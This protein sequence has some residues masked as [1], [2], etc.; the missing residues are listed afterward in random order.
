MNHD[1]TE[2]QRR[3]EAEVQAQRLS[4]YIELIEKKIDAWEA[5]I[6]EIDDLD[7][8]AVEQQFYQDYF[9][10]MLESYFE[11]REEDH[12][13][14]S[15]ITRFLADLDYYQS[16]ARR[17]AG[18]FIT[19]KSPASTRSSVSHYATIARQENGQPRQQ[20]PV[21]NRPPTILPEATRE[22]R[23]Q[24]QTGLDT[25]RAP[26]PAPATMP[27]PSS[28]LPVDQYIRPSGDSRSDQI[29]PLTSQSGSVVP[30]GVVPPGVTTVSRDGHNNI[31]AISGDPVDLERER[32]GERDHH[33]SFVTGTLNTFAPGGTQRI[34]APS[35]QVTHP[36]FG[37]PTNNTGRKE[38]RVSATDGV[39]GVGGRSDEM[40]ERRRQ[41]VE[42]RRRQE[43]RDRDGAIGDN[44]NQGPR[45]FPSEGADWRHREGLNKPS[46]RYTTGGL[47]SLHPVASQLPPPASV[48]MPL[49]HP[50]QSAPSAPTS[51]QLPVMPL[52][53]FDGKEPWT[54]RVFLE[55]F[56]AVVIGSHQ[57]SDLQRLHYLRSCL[58]GEA[59]DAISSVVARE[60]CYTAA[61]KR[62]STIYNGGP[63]EMAALLRRK[64]QGI[65]RGDDGGAKAE[66]KTIREVTTL[67]SEL[68]AHESD[69][70]LLADLVVERLPE[71]AVKKAVKIRLDQPYIPTLELLEKLEAAAIHNLTVEKITAGK[72]KKE[73]VRVVTE[74]SG[75]EEEDTE[76]GE[77]YRMIALPMTNPPPTAFVQREK[78]CP[79]C[80]KHSAGQEERCRVFKS[81]DER[82][83]RCRQ[84]K[85]CFRC[86]R[87]GV[88]HKFRDC[89]ASCLH[90]NGG[91]HASLCKKTHNDRG[92]QK[93]G[94]G[95]QVLVDEGEEGDDSYY[96]E[97][98]E[99]FKGLE[100]D[101]VLP[102]GEIVG[103]ADI[104]PPPFLPRLPSA[105]LLTFTGHVI[106][107]KDGRAYPANIMLDPGAS[108]SLISNSLINR[109]KMDALGRAETAFSGV[110]GATS[111]YQDRRVFQFKVSSDMQGA[112]PIEV[113][114]YELEDPLTGPE[115]AYELT[116][117]DLSYIRKQRLASALLE[118]AT[119]PPDVLV[120]QDP[121]SECLDT[122]V[123][124]VRLPSGM[125]L[126]P[127]TLGFIRTGCMKSKKESAVHCF[128]VPEIV[129]SLQDQNRT[130]E[131]KKETESEDV[132]ILD[133]KRR[134]GEIKKGIHQVLGIPLQIRCQVLMP[135]ELFQELTV[136]TLRTSCTA[137]GEERRV[138][139]VE[140]RKEK[141]VQMLT[142]VRDPNGFIAPLT[143]HLKRLARTF[144]IGERKNG[145]RL[146]EQ[147]V[148][149][150]DNCCSMIRTRNL[151]TPMF[152]FPSFPVDKSNGDG[153]LIIFCTS[154]DSVYAAAVYW[155]SAE[156][157][158][159]HL[160]L[161]QS[162][163]LP[164]SRPDT[165]KFFA[166][167]EAELRA[168]ELG[169]DLLQEAVTA[170][171]SEE[172]PVR[173]RRV[174]CLTDDVVTIQRI[175]E[176]RPEIKEQMNIFALK[177]LENIWE[178][179]DELRREKT[180]KKEFLRWA[181]IQKMKNP[182]RMAA[183]GVNAEHLENP[184]G[185]S[186]Q[187]WWK[188]TEEKGG[189]RTVVR[190]LE[191]PE[192][193]DLV[194]SEGRY[195]HFRA[196]DPMY[197]KIRPDY[198]AA[199]KDWIHPIEETDPLYIPPEE[200]EKIT[201]FN[202]LV[203]RLA[204]K[205]REEHRKENTS[206]MMP[207]DRGI[208]MTIGPLTEAEWCYAESLLMRQHQHRFRS[209][210][211]TIQDLRPTKD[212]NRV[213]R[214]G[215]T[216]QWM[217]EMDTN[218]DLKFPIIIFPKDKLAHLIIKKFHHAEEHGGI[219]TTLQAIRG[220]F[221]IVDGTA[222]VKKEIKRCPTCRKYDHHSHS[223]P[224]HQCL[225]RTIHFRKFEE[226]GVDCMGPIKYCTDKGTEEEMFVLI[227]T[228][229]TSRAI[230]LECST[231][232]N[233]S[234]FINAFDRFL[235]S[236]GGPIRTLWCDTSSYFVYDGRKYRKHPEFIHLT[237]DDTGEL[238]KILEDEYGI[239][240]RKEEIRDSQV[241]GSWMILS[242]LFK[243]CYYTTIGRTVLSREEVYILMEQ[244]ASTINCNP[245]VKIHHWL[246]ENRS[247]PSKSRQQERS[248]RR[249]RRRF[250]AP[251][252]KNGTAEKDLEE[253]GEVIAREHECL[254]PVSARF[255][256]DMCL[257]KKAIVRFWKIWNSAKLHEM[258]EDH[259]E[260]KTH[261]IYSAQEIQLDMNVLLIDHPTEPWVLG[262]ITKIGTDEMGY[263][264]MAK[265]LTDD[266]S[267]SV[268]M[269]VEDVIPLHLALE[270]VS[271]M[272]DNQS[273]SKRR[274]DDSYELIPSYRSGRRDKIFPTPPRIMPKEG[275]CGCGLNLR[276]FMMIGCLATLILP[277]AASDVRQT[278]RCRPHGVEVNASA[279]YGLQVCSPLECRIV[280]P[281]DNT[282]SV[283]MDFPPIMG[284]SPF[285]VFVKLVTENSTF[286]SQRRC[287]A[288]NICDNLEKDWSLDHLLHPECYPWTVF[289][290]LAGLLYLVVIISSLCIYMTC[291]RKV[292]GA[293]ILRS[294]WRCHRCSMRGMGKVGWT[295]G[296]IVS[297]PFR[298]LRT[299]V[300]WLLARL[301]R[302]PRARMD[303]K[304]ERRERRGRMDAV[305]R[306]SRAVLGIAVIL[307]AFPTHALDCHHAIATAE[308]VERCR[309]GKCLQEKG[310]EITTDA[311][312]GSACIKITKEGAERV[313]GA[314][315]IEVMKNQLICARRTKGLH[316]EAEVHVSSS[317]R[318]AF[319]GSCSK[320]I[321]ED[322]KTSDEIE[323]FDHIV[324][325]P[326]H[327]R[328]VESG[329][330]WENG[331]L[332]F[333]SACLFYKTYLQPTST[334]TYESLQC[335]SWSN[336]VTIRVNSTTGQN[337]TSTELV[338]RE[339]EFT[340]EM[341]GTGIRMLRLDEI[342]KADES[343]ILRETFI[344]DGSRMAVTKNFIANNICANEEAA[345]D[346]RCSPQEKCS[347]LP[348]TSKV[349]CECELTS[350][351]GRFTLESTLPIRLQTMEISLD[352]D[353]L[354]PIVQ[355]KRGNVKIY[356]VLDE[357]IEEMIVRE[358]EM[359]CEVAAGPATGC[360]GCEEGAE[361]SFKCKAQE[362][363]EVLIS[364]EGNAIT[365]PCGPEIVKT[366]KKM[367]FDRRDVEIDCQTNCN[368]KEVRVKGTLVSPPHLTPSAI[369][370]RVKG[371]EMPQWDFLP[372]LQP[373]WDLMAEYWKETIVIAVIT[374]LASL[375]T[376][377]LAVGGGLG[378]I[379]WIIPFCWH[380]TEKKK[381]QAAKIK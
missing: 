203:E 4:E 180:D 116:D 251:E 36:P 151:T 70:Y 130:V 14:D 319:V 343:E 57:L 242:E 68:L 258:R 87:S 161:A 78:S 98:E 177:R 120:G 75:K 379:G 314:I 132:S 113:T 217:Q 271:M 211:S 111:E 56:Q 284:A 45:L 338:M 170:L 276:A 179:E 278:L 290:I 268:I 194:S 285:T 153:E 231:A 166:R 142:K 321:C 54:F 208:I 108:C 325:F 5:Q 260:R 371:G 378:W 206:L 230:R 281:A 234:K 187:L 235:L 214:N 157:D 117:K 107:Q 88:G 357:K 28:T 97:M 74:C 264:R 244:M 11:I 342:E 219:R 189:L 373:L 199:M 249:L 228:C 46:Q 222:A 22:R 60:G 79:L 127:T 159:S 115:R 220:R 61:I 335:T 32:R 152:P 173:I 163:L 164:L 369:L 156:D 178:K 274:T 329:G 255:L 154:A 349:N 184:Q 248:R 353:T 138:D 129:S 232:M 246:K 109:M 15:P 64:I 39:M 131:E 55:T 20:A 84:L 253:A 168:A 310:I 330:G 333:H 69:H 175:R 148:K 183:L 226:T 8:R 37:I 94:V 176:R 124:Y 247:S 67:V 103:A 347:C 286:T 239:R 160:M 317:K 186:A 13:S 303:E 145:W 293:E 323:E 370:S 62:L 288:S 40:E 144:K 65:K 265:V 301:R 322:L 209:S 89:D 34:V 345:K 91:H 354:S 126:T 197:N 376:V 297:A 17:H 102:I 188:G 83:A 261:R 72:K 23:Q 195:R 316:R 104:K 136:K 221:W 18:H 326:G 118:D 150:L 200:I 19:A 181:L 262:T 233:R 257:R 123:K 236:G 174:T 202:R 41:E 305:R 256:T 324:Q 3:Q 90:C 53:T 218:I 135:E 125:K 121:S 250:A 308:E 48:G 49:S 196:I 101:R 272:Y 368:E 191:E 21:P 128:T 362:E 289:A 71:N 372:N 298:I 358:E 361:V 275:S 1:L 77:D 33:L 105:K 283:I 270:E 137:T 81:P 334:K 366:K 351:E 16:E 304:K 359:D 344:T 198:V 99:Q 114:A 252:R 294:I 346:F 320:N 237:L 9:Q 238:G 339:G 223:A 182:A 254:L 47:P 313:E 192:N 26:L 58:R 100:E 341:K 106:N 225:P 364:C 307:L 266:G 350:V 299:S 31:G 139:A 50:W 7:Q 332:S 29:P 296:W 292:T 300:S 311:I 287:P 169:M 241:N 227:F 263:A 229:M 210:W 43:I 306:A 273:E 96:D 51:L 282:G 25:G 185:G 340:H 35:H 269:A 365:I 259:L 27:H 279:G 337:T 6:R 224:P 85:L 205:I 291:F 267:T 110:G 141:F 190:S 380:Q 167:P 240:W 309:E 374:L 42:E 76:E 377:S 243:R 134:S 367:F 213:M 336:R 63:Q 245:V 93:M 92:G 327:T 30:P 73:T 312:S 331:C 12:E 356:L 360:H 122:G 204:E 315:S 140:V 59:L 158:S 10:D 82:I 172:E 328:C 318:C 133:S 155:L 146:S 193:P 143:I 375:I 119:G 52:P 95:V 86:L 215:A 280:H 277:A 112:V 363:A 212:H 165:R 348:V 302:P 2:E 171:G 201:E 149:E 162:R 44:Y 66:L 216:R 207:K 355:L 381:E 80:G 38:D 24:E 147:Q 295:I 352:Y